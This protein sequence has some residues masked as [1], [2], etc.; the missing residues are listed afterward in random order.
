MK[1][2]ITQQGLKKALLGV[3][4]MLIMMTEEEK[5]EMDEKVLSLI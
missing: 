2:L 1:A 3:D 4:N 5:T